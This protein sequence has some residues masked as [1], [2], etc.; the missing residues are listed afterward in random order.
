M[1]AFNFSLAGVK[2]NVRLTNTMDCL[3]VYTYSMCIYA[4]FKHDNKIYQEVNIVLISTFV[5]SSLYDQIM[6]IITNDT[7]T[8]I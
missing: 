5:I 7:T 8:T 6:M 4:I 1:L 3:E 2:V